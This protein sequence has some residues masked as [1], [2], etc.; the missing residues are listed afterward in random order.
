MIEIWVASDSVYNFVS[1]ICYVF[2]NFNYNQNYVSLAMQVLAKNFPKPPPQNSGTNYFTLRVKNFANYEYMI[3]SCSFIA[4]SC[5]R[6]LI[7]YATD[8]LF[9][10]CMN[11]VMCNEWFYY[12]NACINQIIIVLHFS[13]FIQLV[14]QAFLIK[15]LKR[16]WY[17]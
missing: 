2:Q 11:N 6:F 12:F 7:S 10:M 1:Y 17:A 4:L 15:I 14:D 9:V 3:K 16:T 13:S 5:V 8:I